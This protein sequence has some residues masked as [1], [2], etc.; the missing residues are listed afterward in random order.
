MS[1]RTR[2]PIY[3]TIKHGGQRPTSQMSVPL[4]AINSVESSH[5]SK[6]LLQSKKL[7]SM[8]LSDGFNTARD[9]TGTFTSD[10]HN[11]HTQQRRQQELNSNQSKDR[12]LMASNELFANS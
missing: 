11:S 8:L 1:S 9:G 10:S 6:D 3:K 7:A 5:Y 12:V 2:T 4:S